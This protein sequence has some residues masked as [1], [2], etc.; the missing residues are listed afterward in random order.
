MMKAMQ[1]LFEW[2]APAPPRKPSRPGFPVLEKDAELRARAQEILQKAG[3]EKLARKVRVEWSARLKT[4]AG[5]ACY[6]D[7]LIRLNPQLQRFGETEIDRTLRHE[8][9]HLVAHDGAGRRRIAAHG[10]EW[11]AACAQLGIPDEN[12][13]HT[14]PLQGRRRQAKKLCYVCKTCG[15]KVL[16]VRP[17][18]HRSACLNCCRKHNGGRYDERF[19]FVKV[20]LVP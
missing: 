5:I 1:M 20:P 10:P 15:E 6:R 2:L 4:T 18:K 14:L 13:C 9:A 8:L 7:C 16:R 17:F 11:R 3:L 19:R 12:R